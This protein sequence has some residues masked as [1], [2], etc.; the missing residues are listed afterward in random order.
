M[1]IALL[2]LTIGFVSVSLAAQD[3][4]SIAPGQRVRLSLDGH[5]RISGVLKSQDADS[6][7]VQQYWEDPPIAIARTRIARI[8]LSTHRHSN[9]GRDAVLGL[10]VGGTVGALAGASCT[11]EWLCPGPAAAGAALGLTSMVFGAVVGAF[12]HS[13]TWQSV[14]QRRVQVSVTAPQRGRGI[15][16]GVAVAF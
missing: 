14:Y 6:I 9:V 15:G 7:R 11:D 5:R 13:E 1:R 8:E 4:L 10:F 2:F 16:V 3:S 12:S